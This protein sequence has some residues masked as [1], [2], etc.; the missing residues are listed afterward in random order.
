MA[1]WE[2]FNVGQYQSKQPPNNQ[3]SDNRNSQ[4]GKTYG[5]KKIEPKQLPVDFV[6][7]A[8][9]VMISLGKENHEDSSKM[10][11]DLTTSKIRNI[12]SLVTEVYNVESL[13]TDEKLTPESLRKIQMIRVRI[14]YEA[15][16]EE[17]VVKP[18]VEK[19]NILSYILDIGNGRK[20]FINFAQYMEALV[21][22]HRFLGGKD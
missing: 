17:K 20:K 5:P 15:G 18:F 4:Q 2:T 11:F 13:R 16:R 1:K 8:E 3:Y 10:V 6:D 12:L 19:S 22:Y 9:K 14:L 7:E 21:A